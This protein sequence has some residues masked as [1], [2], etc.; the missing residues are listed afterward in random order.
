MKEKIAVIGMGVSGAGVLLAYAK[1]LPHYPA[2]EVELVCFDSSESFGRGKPFREQSVHALNNSRSHTISYDFEDEEDFV[3]WLKIEGLEVPEFTSRKLFGDYLNARTQALV[4][5]LGASV[6]ETKVT[7]VKWLP[8]SRQWQLQLSADADGLEDVRAEDLLFDRL[9][10]CCGELPAADYYDLKGQPHYIHEPYPLAA[11]KEGPK[12]GDSVAVI[13]TGLSALDVYKYLYDELGIREL[14]LFSR[15]NYFPSVRGQADSPYQCKI[16]TEENVRV[17]IKQQEGRFSFEN[18][19]TLLKAELAQLGI[20]L[21][22]F[23][24]T[25]FRR[26]IEGVLVSYHNPDLV[27]LMQ[28]VMLQ[29]SIILTEGWAAMNES[30]RQ[31]F[32]ERYDKLLVAFRNPMPHASAVELLEGVR[33]KEITI[34]WD[35][36]IIEACQRPSELTPEG[37]EP[38]FVLGLGEGDADV[39]VDWVVN[40]TGMDLAM[41]DLE[42]YDLL[43][44]LVDQRLVQ[45]DSAGGLSVNFESLNLISPRYGE[46]ASLHGHG[47]LVGGAIYQNNSTFKIQ[48]QAQRLVR[49]LL[50]QAEV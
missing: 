18:F 29:A 16:L 32:N 23:I 45:V 35:V 4:S 39:V 19:E 33:N 31:Q 40:A 3:N 50:A 7:A 26:G 15:S 13:G 47:M 42:G 12:P 37:V 8:A 21:T 22:Y 25:F 1:E 48:G 36:S 46:W 30:D 2:A 44:R 17:S 9:H 49:R 14:K 6:I 20:D 38:Y 43:E 34:L 28:Q 41:R 24:E 27:S 10:L 11:L 5:E